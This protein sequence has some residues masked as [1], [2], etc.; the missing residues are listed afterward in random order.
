VKPG[1]LAVLLTAML[2][3]PMVNAGYEDPFLEIV[4]GNV[5]GHTVWQIEGVDTNVGKTENVLGVDT[6]Y[7]YP[8]AA[9]V[10]NVSSSSPSDTWNGT[11]AWNITIYGLDANLQPVSE[12]LNLSGQTPVATVHAY[13]RVNLIEIGSAGA[14]E[15][16]VGTIYIGVGPVTA[17]V[18]ATIYHQAA[19]GVGRS[20]T[21]VY[22]VPHGYT[23]YLRYLT[24]GTVSS[25]HLTLRMRTRP[26][27]GDKAWRND[28]YEEFTTEHVSHSMVV[29]YPIPGG[30]DIEFRCSASA[31]GASATLD[32]FLVLVEDG[33]K[34]INHVYS[35]KVMSGGDDVFNT[36][37]L[38]LSLLATVLSFAFYAGERVVPWFIAII[39]GFLAGIML[40]GTGFYWL[41][42]GTV[43]PVYAWLFIVWGTVNLLLVL[44]VVLELQRGGRG[45]ASDEELYM[46]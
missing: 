11:G 37:L 10:M 35:V 30:S 32:A 25:Q 39:L 17:G 16:N 33:Y 12:S 41:A 5:P 9:T 8:A 24:F 23:A 31:G 1:P 46:T 27:N 21:A 22:T 43:I 13:L 6:N 4:K 45:Y 44:W 29:P 28:Y 15:V 34:D 40:F 2:L 19:P 3:V 20:S 14:A 18:P 38:V 42:S 7:T 36:P 26:A